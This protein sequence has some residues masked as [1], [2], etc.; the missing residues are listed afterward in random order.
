M[1]PSTFYLWGFLPCM[2]AAREWPETDQR[3]AGERPEF[4]IKRRLG[5]SLLICPHGY[6]L[7]SSTRGYFRKTA[8]V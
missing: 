8:G 4:N 3:A 5:A 7:K 1:M 6:L 2:R